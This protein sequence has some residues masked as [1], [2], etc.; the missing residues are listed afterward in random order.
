[1]HVVKEKLGHKMLG[2]GG[3]LD[4][5]ILNI[6]QQ[7]VGLGVSL[8]V[9]GTV[10]R[11]IRLLPFNEGGQVACMAEVRAFGAGG[12][13]VAAQGQYIADTDSLELVENLSRADLVVAHAD[14]MRKRGDL[15]LVLDIVGN[16]GSGNTA[17]RAACAEGDA[18]EPGVE[19]LHLLQGGFQLVHLGGLSRRKAFDRENTA[20]SFELFGDRH[21]LLLVITPQERRHLR[22]SPR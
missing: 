18:D 11:E 21:L 16:L 13:A 15:Q 2:T 4:P 20:F 17:G 7:G 14:Q 22:W 10:Y 19:R 1:M 5:Q 6:V 12:A 3:L 9:A 8:R